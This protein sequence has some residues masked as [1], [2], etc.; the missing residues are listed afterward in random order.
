MDQI[1]LLKESYGVVKLSSVE[2]LRRF[3]KEINHKSSRS[4]DE[5]SSILIKFTNSTHLL[6]SIELIAFPLYKKQL[7]D[8]YSGINNPEENDDMDVLNK[9]CL[10]AEQMTSVYLVERSDKLSN[11]TIKDIEQYKDWLTKQE[12]VT[13]LLQQG[14]VDQEILS[15]LETNI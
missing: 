6:K 7:T 11:Q 1:E 9:Y 14:I 10:Q 5:I 2:S 4:I 15:K 8:L 3:I 13:I 12:L